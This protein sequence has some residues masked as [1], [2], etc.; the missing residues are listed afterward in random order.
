VKKAKYKIVTTNRFKK[1]YARMRT[2]NNFNEKDF[3]SIITKL[4]NDEVLPQKYRNH[5]LEPKKE[6]YMGMSYTARLVVNIY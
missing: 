4:A 5:L 1:D 3:W 2:R 6:R